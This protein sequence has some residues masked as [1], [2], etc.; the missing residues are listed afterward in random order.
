MS[1]RHHRVR[2]TWNSFWGDLLLRRFHEDNPKRW[3]AREAKAH[4][5]IENLAVKPGAHIVDL[6]C[7]DGVLDICLARKGYEVTALDR[8]APVLEAARKE[9]EGC[10][11]QVNFAVADVRTYDFGVRNFHGAIFF[12]SLGLMGR[13]EEMDMLAALRRGLRPH[14]FVAMDWPARGSTTS[15]ER[16]F[17]DGLLT[18]S[19]EYDDTTRVQTIVPEFHHVDGRIIELHDPY[20]PPDHLGVRRYI[21]T[22]EEAEAL[23]RHAGFRSQVVPHY[24]THD[25]HMILATP[26]Q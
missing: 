21:Y 2:E 6:D 1:R 13:D 4:W 26:E 18:A 25:Y 9:A 10:G 12:D 15:W 14:A 20:G 3:S 5:L 8:I 11:V 7:G 24:S 19:A 17:P 16:T 22:Q 23:L